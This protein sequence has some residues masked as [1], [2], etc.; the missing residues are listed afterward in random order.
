VDLP[1]LAEEHD[2]SI[3]HFE[4]NEAPNNRPQQWV[5]ISKTLGEK[6]R[7]ILE[8]TDKDLQCYEKK[9]LKDFIHPGASSTPHGDGDSLQILYERPKTTAERLHGTVSYDSEKGSFLIHPQIARLWHC[10]LILTVA[11]LIIVYGTCVVGANVEFSEGMKRYFFVIAMAAS[12]V[13]STLFS[14]LVWVLGGA[15]R[16]V[17]TSFVTVSAL[18]LVVLQVCVPGWD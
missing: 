3:I 5:M 9:L 8:T 15:M 2:L 18:C 7:T 14:W 13:L 4:R 16:D 17:T 10:V 1:A 6:S 12:L 11:V